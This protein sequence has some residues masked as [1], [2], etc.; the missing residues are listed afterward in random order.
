[1]TLNAVA[2]DASAR[3]LF[4]LADQINRLGAVEMKPVGLSPPELTELLLPF[5]SDVVIVS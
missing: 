4:G 2:M 5:H 3:Q 1:M